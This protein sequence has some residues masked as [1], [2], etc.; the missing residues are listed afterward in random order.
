MN[1]KI[2]CKD[3]VDREEE[4]VVTAG[5]AEAEAE[6]VGKRFMDSVLGHKVSIFPILKDSS[7]CFSIGYKASGDIPSMPMGGG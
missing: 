7:N 1:P 3:L 5:E 4:E 2:W 6:V